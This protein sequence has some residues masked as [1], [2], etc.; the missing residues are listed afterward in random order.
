MHGSMRSDVAPAAATGDAEPAGTRPTFTVVIAVKNGARTLQR[1]LD[2]VFEQTY[3]GIEVIVMD[4]GSTDG[5]QAI[6]ERNTDRIAYWES[7]PDRGLCHAWNKA[8]ARATGE[9]ICF[10]GADDRYHDR[11]VFAGIAAALPEDVATTRVVY[12]QLARLKDDGWVHHR[13]GRPWG[14]RRKK[15]RRGEMIPHPATFHHRSLF[16]EHGGFDERFA[17]AGDYEFLLR[18]LLHHRPAF[19]PLIVV[20]MSPGGISNRPS[21]APRMAREVYRARYMHHLVKTP[22]WRSR[23]LASQLASLWLDQHVRPRV[24]RVRTLVGRSSPPGAS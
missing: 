1:A 21:T 19:V 18:E 4:G 15:F 6:L 11:E 24:T 23:A 8:V 9:W 2:S 7:V 10:L 3:E 20:D 14:Q 17:I 13:G 16:A 22:P 12:G 5:T